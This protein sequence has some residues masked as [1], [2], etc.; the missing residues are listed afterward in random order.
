MKLK[1]RFCFNFTISKIGQTVQTVPIFSKKAIFRWPDILRCEYYRYFK[2]FRKFDDG[3]LPNAL[4]LGSRRSKPIV[5]SKPGKTVPLGHWTISFETK[6]DHVLAYLEMK[7]RTNKITIIFAK[8]SVV[9]PWPVMILQNH[10][11]YHFPLRGNF[12]YSKS[13]IFDPIYGPLS[14]SPFCQLC[15]ECTK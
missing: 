15:L 11:Q 3:T 1:R 9:F 7:F 12:L 6:T 14:F 2:S 10:V 5:W 13:L 8:S 4:P